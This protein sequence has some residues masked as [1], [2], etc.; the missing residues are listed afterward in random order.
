MIQNK[1]KTIK[2]IKEWIC[3]YAEKNNKSTLIVIVD[4]WQGTEL[5]DRICNSQTKFKIGVIPKTIYAED[6]NSSLINLAQNSNGILIS[7]LNK[8]QYYLVRTQSKYGAI[9]GDIYPLIDL[10]QSEINDLLY[11]NCDVAYDDPRICDYSLPEIEWAQEENRKY[12]LIEN[13]ELPQHT[14]NWF[15][16]TLTQKKIISK[17]HQREK[18]T[19]HKII[20]G[21]PIL[22]F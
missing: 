15:K 12:G 22:K 2:Q 21:R 16:Y 11:P 13:D 18:Q 5:L 9:N 7:P 14:S 20:S 1:E 19:R 6:Y 3:D 8:S 10:Y 4:K 17:L